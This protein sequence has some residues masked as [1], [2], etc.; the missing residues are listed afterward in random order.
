VGCEIPQQWAYNCS[1]EGCG[2]AQRWMWNSSA[3]GVWN[4]SAV[5]VE[6][7]PVGVRL[8][9]LSCGLWDCS[10]VGCG[11]ANAVGVELF[12][13]CCGVDHSRLWPCLVMFMSLQV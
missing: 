10:A 3:A 4:C 7:P 6:L 12:S 9:M 8:A 2:I 5:G 13:F 1:V 11:I